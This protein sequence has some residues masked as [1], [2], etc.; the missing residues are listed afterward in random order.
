MTIAPIQF[1]SS[2]A[3]ASP[4]SPL[5]PTAAE[6]KETSQAD[7]KAA[8]EKAEALALQRAEAQAAQEA[9]AKLAQIISTRDQLKD[10]YERCQSELPQPKPSTQDIKTMNSVL[11]SFKFGTLAAGV[12]TAVMGSLWAIPLMLYP[13]ASETYKG[14]KKLSTIA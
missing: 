13:I 11:E 6:P 7:A 4:S 9:Q 5:G 14:L 2:A 10:M 8:A 3:A 12:A 1:S